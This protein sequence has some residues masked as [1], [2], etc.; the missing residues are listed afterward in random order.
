MF[1]LTCL[2]PSLQFDFVKLL[3][4]KQ[5]NKQEMKVFE[6]LSSEQR[7]L[8]L[9][10]LQETSFIEYLDPGTW[11][12]ALYNDGK[13]MEQILLLSNTISKSTKE[14]ETSLSVKL[15]LKLF[16]CPSFKWMRKWLYVMKEI[17]HLKEKYY[18]KSLLFKLPWSPKK[19]EFWNSLI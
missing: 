19:K 11:Y 7:N 1:I 12:L 14:Q 15:Y 2:Y 13:K 6:N 16:I 8:Q 10:S 17:I 5:L 4:G 9:H 3:D 18:I